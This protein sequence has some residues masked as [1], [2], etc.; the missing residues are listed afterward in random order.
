MDVGE[1]RWERLEVVEVGV[2][3]R[4]RRGRLVVTGGIHASISNESMQYLSADLFWRAAVS[5]MYDRPCVH[6]QL[7]SLLGGDAVESSR[8]DSGLCFRDEP[9]RGK[10][11]RRESV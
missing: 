5:V 2:A 9:L 7:V 10:T 11:T 4:N 1:E 3:L 6:S 8:A